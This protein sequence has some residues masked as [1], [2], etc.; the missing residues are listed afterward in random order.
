VPEQ[1]QQQTENKGADAAAAAAAA[2][3]A[4][5]KQ[6]RESWAGKTFTKPELKA[7]PSLAKFQ[8]HDALGESYLALEK[9]FGDKNAHVRPGPDSTPEEKADFNKWLGVP[10]GA[11]KYS[12][13]ADAA[14]IKEM[15]PEGTPI[16]EAFVKGAFETFYKVGLTDEQANGVIG[17]FAEQQAA[18]MAAMSE[19][20][21]KGLDDL[22]KS[23][24]HAYEAKL[25]VAGR[26]IDQL[27]EGE[28]KI[29]GLAE[30]MDP[31]SN[32]PIALW[33]QS[34][35]AMIRL[36]MFLGEAMGEDE[37]VEGEHRVEQQVGDLKTKKAELMKTGS[38]YWLK[39]HADHAKFVNDVKAINEQLTS[40]GAGA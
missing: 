5:D 3:Q 34:N 17:F 37:L 11:D 26:A 29:P 36:F 12:L 39:D 31:K 24:G 14:K 19:H 38:P 40:N 27:C 7:N 2:K 13:N 21:T 9:K 4:S 33:V 16:K 6:Q 18:E 1:Q 23:L 35:P 30:V 20:L 22:K 15:L 25:A 28:N 10:E 32:D 8:N